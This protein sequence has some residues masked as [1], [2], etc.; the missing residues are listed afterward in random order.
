MIDQII[1]YVKKKFI[2]YFTIEIKENIH[3]MNVNNVMG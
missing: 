3:G 2:Y 1:I